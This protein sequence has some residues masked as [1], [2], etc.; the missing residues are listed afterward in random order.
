[1]F[2]CAALILALGL[3]RAVWV[4]LRGSVRGSEPGF[5]PPARRPSPGPRPAG[6]RPPGAGPGF[7]DL[8]QPVRRPDGGGAAPEATLETSLIVL[9]HKTL[10]ANQFEEKLRLSEPPVI[11]RVAEIS[12]TWIAIGAGGVHLVLAVICL[13]IG[14]AKAVKPP[15][16]E[17]SAELQKDREW[18]KK[19]DQTS[20]P[21]H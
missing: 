14:Y 9:T 6:E 3:C 13:L 4:F 18:L 7:A 12:W 8:G 15:F 17:L 1:M 21:T 20:R 10:S 11:A 16:R 19:L 5:A 2:C